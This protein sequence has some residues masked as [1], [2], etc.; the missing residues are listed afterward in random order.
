[1]RKFRDILLCAL[2][3][4]GVRMLA[5]NSKV[6]IIGIPIIDEPLGQALNWLKKFPF[7]VYLNRFLDLF[8]GF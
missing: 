4:A 3:F 7:T 2:L 5:I 6:T 8:S 1:M